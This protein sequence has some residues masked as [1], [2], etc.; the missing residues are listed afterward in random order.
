MIRKGKY[1]YYGKECSYIT[2]DLADTKHKNRILEI[3]EEKNVDNSYHY[4]IHAEWSKG[5]YHA[6]MK[7]S[8]DDL[9]DLTEALNELAQEIRERREEN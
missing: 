9:L 2:I 6:T 1:D 5:K 3:S 4:D 7:M 8:E